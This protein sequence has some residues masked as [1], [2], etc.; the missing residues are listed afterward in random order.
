MK[1]AGARTSLR[2][3]SGVALRHRSGCLLALSSSEEAV[4][5]EEENCAVR[6]RSVT[7][8]AHPAQAHQPASGPDPLHITGTLDINAGIGRGRP[9]DRRSAST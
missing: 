3:G 7:P 8:T 1:A 5:P 9:G 6:H 2:G 4:L